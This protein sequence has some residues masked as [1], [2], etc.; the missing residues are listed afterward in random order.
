MRA[1]KRATAFDTLSVMTPQEVLTNIRSTYASCRSYQDRGDVV[2]VF[3][4]GGRRRTD[5]RPFFTWFVRPH[6]FRF[7]FANRDIGPEDEW[8]RHVVWQRDGVT[9]SWW[10]ITGPRDPESLSMALAGATGISGRS[11][12]RIPRLLLPEL[13]G[14]QQALRFESDQIVMGRQ[15]RTL[16]KALNNSEEL[17]AVDPQTW[18]ILRVTER[19]VFDKASRER[20]EREMEQMRP[21]LEARGIHIPSMRHT[22]DFVTETTTTY[23]PVLDADIPGHVFEFQPPR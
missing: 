12:I 10:S 16:V 17:W 5:S 1:H 23:E 11:A 7:E 14:R 4:E 21:Q 19:K 6:L 8:D 13:G 18:L 9:K 2:T 20:E 3:H 15:C 22:E